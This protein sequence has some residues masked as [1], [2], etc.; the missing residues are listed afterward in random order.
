VSAAFRRGKSG[1]L[2]VYVPLIEGRAQRSIGTTD[3][4]V[5]RQVRAMLAELKA[6]HRW[7]I[8]T[9]L[10]DGRLSFARALQAWGANT[11]AQLEAELTA[12]NL[13]DHLPGWR[14]WVKAHRRADVYTDATYW[15]QVTSL[16]HGR[17]LVTDLTKARVTAWLAG[18]TCTSGTK[19]KYRYALGSFVRYLLDVGVLD[20]D[21]LAGLKTPKKNP[22]RRRWA[23]EAT[24]RAIVDAVTVA[25]YRPLF[26]FIKATGADVGSALRAQRGDLDLAAGTVR[27]RGTKT[28]RRH[29]ESAALE[30]WALP[31]LRA[32]C[33][34]I[35]GR[36]ALL[37][38][39]LTRHGAAHHHEHCCR[40]VGVEDYTLKDARHSVAN[41]MRRAGKSFEQIAAQLGTSLFHAVS[42]YADAGQEEVKNNRTTT[43]L[44]TRTSDAARVAEG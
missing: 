39:G 25:K 6:R 22:K 19:R 14:Q 42:T 13:T 10:A 4:A 15:Q 12:V 8:L 26:A 40:A 11:L 32:H 33:Q 41:R 35:L 30:P 1:N 9:A 37:F 44:T 38:P 24:D 23:D 27:I 3:K 28:D 18:L 21:P 5:A 17:F 16:V 31:I 43:D 36:H 7:T 20:T 2:S 34:T 29:V